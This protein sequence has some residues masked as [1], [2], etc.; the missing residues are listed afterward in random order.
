L[1]KSKDEKIQTNV[2]NLL[3]S[4]ESSRDAYTRNIWI[5]FWYLV[6]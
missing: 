4:F 3:K 5:Y 1:F 6:Q 2:K